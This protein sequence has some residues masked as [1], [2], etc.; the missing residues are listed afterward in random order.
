[1]IPLIEIMNR[2]FDAILSM[3]RYKCF[4]FEGKKKFLIENKI[5]MFW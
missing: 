2:K 5:D 4:D 1:M 3:K